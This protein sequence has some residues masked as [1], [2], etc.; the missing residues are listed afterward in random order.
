MKIETYNIL[1]NGIFQG[2][3]QHTKNIYIFTNFF[4][5]YL[6]NKLLLFIRIT[7]FSYTLTTLIIFI[8]Y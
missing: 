6:D 2:T 8:M 1:L 4:T 5:T 3:M 7:S